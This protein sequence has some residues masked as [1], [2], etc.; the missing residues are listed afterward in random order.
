MLTDG[1]SAQSIAR[2]YREV[3]VESL[4]SARVMSGVVDPGA[5]NVIEGA[6]NAAIPSIMPAEFARQA[7]GQELRAALRANAARALIDICD[8]MP[9]PRGQFVEAVAS[10]ARQ[11]S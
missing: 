8:R 9:A 2:I 4:A 10:A 5:Q 1:V 6:F 7:E 11:Q 3:L